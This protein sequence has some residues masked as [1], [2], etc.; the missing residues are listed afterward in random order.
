MQLILEPLVA[1]KVLQSLRSASMVMHAGP[2]HLLPCQYTGLIKQNRAC[3]RDSCAMVSQAK[4]LVDQHAFE[5]ECTGNDERPAQKLCFIA[6]LPHI[7]DSKAAGRQNYIQVSTEPP[8]KPSECRSTSL[9]ESSPQQKQE[10]PNR[11]AVTQTLTLKGSY[12]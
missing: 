10:H 11:T 12:H 9:S 8:N 3:C 4:H 1:N 2:A 7:L 5:S 6:F